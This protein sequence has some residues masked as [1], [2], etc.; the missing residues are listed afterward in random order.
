MSLA[1]L[2][3]PANYGYVLLTT[4]VGSTFVV[5]MFFMGGAV[6]GARSKF[7]VDYPNLYATPGYHKEADAF[8][9]VQRGHQN[10]L[11][12]LTSFTVANLIG[13][14]KYPL[15]C[16]AFAV[17][18]S[19][20]SYLYLV[21]YADATLDVKTARYQKGGQIK[22]IGWL[23]ALGATVMVAGSLVGWWE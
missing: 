18:Y 22:F 7:G 6:M 11:E 16:S 17:L 4:V 15:A 23:G 14:L 5:P 21:G 13:G 19:L 3:V 10:M 12:S 1:T 20:G 9:R 8:N 2:T